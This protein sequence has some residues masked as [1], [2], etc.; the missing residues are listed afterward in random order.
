MILK[1]KKYSKKVRKR[2]ELILEQLKS[3]PDRLFGIW[4]FYG[5]YN[6]KV[7]HNLLNEQL[8]SVWSN[9]SDAIARAL[10]ILVDEEYAVSINYGKYQYSGGPEM[11][12]ARKQRDLMVAD[13]F[14]SKLSL[15][16]EDL[17]FHGFDPPTI[18][19]EAIE[20]LFPLEE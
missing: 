1:K 17:E 7:L 16:M 13:W 9:Q 6:N 2:C 20:I 14:M 5:S 8:R 19:K 3:E 18:K 12:A 11:V 15:S 10:K 4:D